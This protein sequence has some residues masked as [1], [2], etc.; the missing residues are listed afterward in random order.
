MAYH[1]S[2]V[3]ARWREY[4]HDLLLVPTWLN[5]WR[6]RLQL[7]LLGLRRP[8][9]VLVNLG[10]GKD[11]RA[12]Y[13]N[14]D[15]NI[16]FRRDMWLDLRNRL[17]FATG[18]VD[19][20]FCS[21]VLEH[22]PLDQTA[23]IVRECHRVLKPGGVLRVGV[24]DFEPAIRSYQS[25]NLAW[26]HGTGRSPGRLFSDHVLDNSNHRLLFDYSFLH[27]LLGDAGFTEVRQVRF[28]QGGWPLSQQM[29]ELDNRED[30]TV[31]AE[32]RR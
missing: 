17:P 20:I 21:H 1:R 30:I 32:A 9:P 11:Y 6:W 27:E 23:G 16:A 22:F 3:P 5:S 29:A 28:R 19:G 7:R 18:S 10:S 8:E 14:V 25:G 24:P 13:I 12:G 4:Y 31:F 2:R 26:F 15:I